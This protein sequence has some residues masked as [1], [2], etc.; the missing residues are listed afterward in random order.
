MNMC[1]D[2]WTDMWND[3]HQ[4]GIGGLDLMVSLDLAILFDIYLFFFSFFFFFKQRVDSIYLIREKLKTTC[5]SRKQNCRTGEL[6]V[7]CVSY[8]A[9]SLIM[10]LW[11]FFSKALFV[12]EKLQIPA[13]YQV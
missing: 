1:V 5:F 10:P 2:T 8:L 6:R 9:C 11:L 4:N 3:T 13:K 7:T 12:G